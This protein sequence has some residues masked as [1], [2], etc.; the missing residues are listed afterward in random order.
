M[1][2]ISRGF[3]YISRKQD[4]KVCSVAVPIG[5]DRERHPSKNW[6]LCKA[7]SHNHTLSN[8]RRSKNFFVHYKKE[9]NTDLFSIIVGGSPSQ[10]Q[11][12]GVSEFLVGVATRGQADR[13][14]VPGKK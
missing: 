7:K 9:K 3:I 11:R 10:G 1:S 2:L 6:H 5:P 12:K 8:D 4:L 13:L 14:D